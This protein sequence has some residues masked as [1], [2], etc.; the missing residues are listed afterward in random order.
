MLALE[1]TYLL[2]EEEDFQVFLVVG[3]PRNGDKVEQAGQKLAEDKV[4]HGWAH[5]T[6]CAD[7][8]I[9]GARRTK[10]GRVRNCSTHLDRVFAHYRLAQDVAEMLAALLPMRKMRPKPSSPR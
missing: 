6:V 4:Q 3:L 7:R 8:L 5:C 10:A 1:D 2:S 9:S